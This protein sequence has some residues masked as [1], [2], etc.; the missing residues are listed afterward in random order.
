MGRQLCAAAGVQKNS[1]SVA[2]QAA[3]VTAKASTCMLVVLLAPA[4]AA[5]GRQLCA[6]K[7]VEI[8]AEGSSRAADG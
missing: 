2:E 7:T 3:E 8:E 4:T 1:T 5:A 6:A